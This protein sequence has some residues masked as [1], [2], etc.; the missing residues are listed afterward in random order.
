M[1][2]FGF[3]KIEREQPGGGEHTLLGGAEEERS[4]LQMKLH[5][6]EDE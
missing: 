5:A 6:R 3:R 2:Y 1:G 4:E